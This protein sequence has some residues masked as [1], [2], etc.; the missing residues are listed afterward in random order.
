MVSR[1][2]VGDADIKPDT[3]EFDAPRQRGASRGRVSDDLPF[4][5]AGGM[6]I[7][8]EF[9]ADG[10][11]LFKIKGPGGKFHEHRLPVKA[12]TRTVG[13]TFLGESELP[14]IVTGL[15]AGRRP[16]RFAVPPAPTAG[17]M[18]LRLD[19][20]RLKLFD[21]QLYRARRSSTSVTISGPFNIT[22]PGDTPSRRRIFVC[23]PASD[24]DEEPCAR[25]IL[26]EPRTPRV[27]PHGDQRGHQ[28]ADRVLP[29]GRARRQFRKGHRD[30]AARHAG[31][32]RFSV[33]HR[34][35][36]RRQHARAACIAS[37]TSNWRRGFRSSCGAASPMTNC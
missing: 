11:Y 17:K 15:V 26:I 29:D 24:K 21:I 1:L 34:A 7:T 16:R 36:S 3:N 20:A 37:A 31:V 12:G 5:S 23:Q 9:P 33:P 14:E 13:V 22:G 28:P 19:G 27:S 8:Y 32:S 25:K 10:E 18:D 35:R 2:A 6:S 30:G 4:D